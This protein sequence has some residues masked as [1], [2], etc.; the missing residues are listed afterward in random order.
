M[1]RRA[2]WRVEKC[3][4]NEFD[5]ESEGLCNPVCFVTPGIFC[6]QFATEIKNAQRSATVPDTCLV[7]IVGVVS[8][9]NADK[10]DLAVWD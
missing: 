3:D 8:Q 5:L 1:D 7:V 4:S 2:S 9:K 10:G 6:G